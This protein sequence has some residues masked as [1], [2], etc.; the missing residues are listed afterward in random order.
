MIKKLKK[1]PISAAASGAAAYSKLLTLH[2]SFTVA[3]T[4]GAAVSKRMIFGRFFTVAASGAAAMF[5][6]LPQAVINR[7][8]GG[9]TTI[10]KKI[11]TFFYDK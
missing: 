3:G 1:A 8:T 2:R 6:R 5:I 11:Q 9:G 4:P 7:M 10:I